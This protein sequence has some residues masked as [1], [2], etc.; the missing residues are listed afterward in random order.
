MLRAATVLDDRERA[1]DFLA[2]AE[3]YEDSDNLR[4]KQGDI[5]LG[6][7]DKA[8]LF[9]IG[10]DVFSH[11]FTTANGYGDRLYVSPRRVHVGARGGTDTF[12]CAGCH[13]VGGPDGAGSPT[14]NAFVYGDGD[15]TSTAN[16]RNPPALLGL[17]IVQQLAAEMTRD[18]QRER[19]VAVEKAA[20]THASV[21]ATLASKGVSFGHVVAS[22]DGAVDTSQVSGVDPD[23][24]VRPFGWK[25]TVARLR[26]F[27]EDAARTHFGIQSTVLA[28]GNRVRA[29]PAHL[30]A[31]TAW[32]DP[33]ADGKTRELEEG[34]LTAMACYLAMLEAPVILPPHDQGLRD[35][36]ANGSRLF[37][38]IGCAGCHTR[39]LPLRDRQWH[40]T[41]DSTKGEVVIDVLADGEQPKG[42]GEVKLFSDLRR[43]AM[44]SLLA[45]AHGGEDG[46]PAGTFLTRPLWGLAE[47]APYLHDG[48]APTVPEAIEAHGGEAQAAR[49][50]FVALSPDEQ[51]DVHVFLLSLS[52]EPKVR[53]AR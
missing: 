36:W 17:G 8:A 23:L 10:D 25:G 43:H 32:F 6:H 22:P 28:E 50:A 39:E 27:A 5:D 4:V 1:E 20:A 45:D 12:S 9:A 37:D 14:Q 35:R 16:V 15:R 7:Y 46:V 44:G 41:A 21:E 19:A 3:Q 53:F 48:R 38:S 51:A 11:E 13:S 24:V 29:D 40:E 2:A 42:P 52:R 34:V 18:L 30:G 49:D 47:S 26:R 33:D 31:G